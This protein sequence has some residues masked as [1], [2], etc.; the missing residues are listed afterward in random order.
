MGDNVSAKM[1][2]NA[3][4]VEGEG[5]HVIRFNLSLQNGREVSGEEETTD[6]RQLA[7]VTV[8]CDGEEGLDDGGEVRCVLELGWEGGWG[9]AG[10]GLIL[11]DARRR[12]GGMGL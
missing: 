12:R 4:E 8:T 6:E 7:D 10:S 3:P 1:L 11:R 9:R 5:R 2:E